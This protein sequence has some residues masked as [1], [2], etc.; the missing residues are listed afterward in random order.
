VARNKPQR[1]HTARETARNVHYLRDGTLARRL[2]E[3]G[4][5]RRCKSRRSISCTTFSIKDWR[6]GLPLFGF[7]TNLPSQFERS[8]LNHNY[9]YAS[10]ADRPNC[11]TSF[12]LNSDKIA[13]SDFEQPKAGPKGA[14]Q[15]CLE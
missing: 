14:R 13:G 4:S 7:R 1:R 8:T 15:G 11:L 9:G 10:A 12:A 3:D 6:D 2:H 5:S